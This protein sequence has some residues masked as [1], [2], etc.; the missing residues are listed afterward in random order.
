[1]LVAKTARLCVLLDDDS[2]QHLQQAIRPSGGWAAAGRTCRSKSKRERGIEG[3]GHGAPLR[4][5]AFL[6]ATR[7]DRRISRRRVRAEQEQGD[8]AVSKGPVL[9]FL[10]VGGSLDRVKT[11]FIYS[12][13]EFGE[14]SFSIQLG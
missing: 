8:K 12:V 10:L 5:C 2:N 11:T 4:D 14:I 7:P 6:T 1:L 9:S 13:L 3:S